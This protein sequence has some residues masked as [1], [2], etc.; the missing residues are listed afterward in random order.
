VNPKPA[1]KP[2]SSADPVL[3]FLPNL[4]TTGNLLFGSLSIYWVIQGQVNQACVCILVAAL[5][6]IFD[7]R[8]ARLTGSSS[9]FGM[10]YDSL[11]DMVSFGVAPGILLY[12]WGFGDFGRLGWILA[13]GYIVCGALRL[14]RYNAQVKNATIEKNYFKG[15]PIPA[16]A[17]FFATLIVFC[18]ELNWDPLPREALLVLMLGI[19]MLMVSP[20]PFRSFKEPKAMAEHRFTHLVILVVFTLIIFSHW[21]TNLFLMIALYIAGNLLIFLTHLVRKLGSHS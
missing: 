10:E 21:E 5:F 20:I 1:S 12:H 9:L 16:A 18:Q 2:P 6:D 17:T 13:F 4:F 3:F 11:C 15:L 7:G 8:V 14:A 19:S